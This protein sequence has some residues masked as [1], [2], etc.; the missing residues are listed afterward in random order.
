[1]LRNLALPLAA[2][3]A[4]MA[5]QATASAE[6]PQQCPGFCQAVYI[7]VCGMDPLTGHRQTFTN[8]CELHRY[9]CQNHTA[10]AVLHQGRCSGD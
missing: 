7:P 6:A 8:E 10:Y 1:M 3:A 4:L 5:A 2:V 9:N